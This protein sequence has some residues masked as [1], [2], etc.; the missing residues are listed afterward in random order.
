MKLPAWLG[1][2][3][4]KKQCVC[5]IGTE[6]AT[7]RD[8]RGFDHGVIIDTKRRQATL[9]ASLDAEFS[10]D[11]WRSF[12]TDIAADRDLA[13]LSR[14]TGDGVPIVSATFR[15]TEKQDKKD[16]SAFMASRAVQADSL[17]TAASAN[18]V[19]LTP[20]DRQAVREYAQAI[21]ANGMPA[22][23]WPPVADDIDETDATL[24]RVH[25]S[26][27]TYSVAFEADISTSAGLSGLLRSVA[28]QAPDVIR[29]AEIVRPAVA[30]LAE[31][32][33]VGRTVG[34]VTVYGEYP[35]DVAEETDGLMQAVGAHGRLRLHRLI[36]RQ[37]VGLITGA[38]LGALAWQQLQMTGKAAV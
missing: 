36:G 16:T 15:A 21:W 26:G 14:I 20:L 31:D 27:Q 18:G 9:L 13:C 23:Q 5:L 10:D 6:L 25:G 33:E 19:R 11:S 28:Q 1:G 24:C 35:A 30:D 3:P 29:Y 7:F 8:T 17:M 37:Q 32:N 38:G 34:L 2:Q 4:K 12:V 22:N